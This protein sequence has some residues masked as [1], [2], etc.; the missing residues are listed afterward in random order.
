[1][2]KL[3]PGPWMVSPDI[4]AIGEF[5]VQGAKRGSGLTEHNPLIADIVSEADARLIAA[6]PDLYE[7]LSDWLSKTEEDLKI[8]G[9]TNEEELP[10]T[11]YMRLT[12]SRAALKKA[13][14]EK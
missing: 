14:G 12:K 4:S 6:A 9:L 8:S 11:L 5:M 2:S 10:L 13:R 1:M 7:A 3:T